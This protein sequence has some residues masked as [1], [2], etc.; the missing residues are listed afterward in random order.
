MFECAKWIWN[1][2]TDTVDQHMEFVDRFDWD[3]GNVSIALS[4][5][6]D[7][8]LWI[9]GVY[10]ASNQYGDMEQYKIYDTIDITS[11]L[12]PGENRLAILVW[13]FGITDSQRYQ[14][15]P[16]GLIY[17][18]HGEN[19]VLAASDEVTLSRQSRA[20]Q[21]GRQKLITRQLGYSFTYDAGAEDNW[22]TEDTEGFTNSQLTDK[23]CTFYPRPNE[24]LTMFPYK[25]A[26]CIH[27]DKEDSHYLLDLG[28]ETVGV[29]RFSLSS[30][31][32]QKIV[33]SYG[34]SLTDGHVRRII[35]A[36]DFSVDYHAREGENDFTHYMLRF[37]GRY[38]EMDGEIPFT[39]HHAGLIPQ[40]FDVTEKPCPYSDPLDREIYKI[41]VNALKLCM[42][43][44]YVDTPWREQC[45]YAYDSRNQMLCGYYAFADGNYAYAR[46]NLLLLAKALRKD[47]L[48][49]IC[50]PCG[51]ELT[52]PSFSMQ[53]IIA[54]KEY[55]EYSG[56]TSLAEE[57]ADVMETLLHT[58]VGRVQDGI[59]Y[60]FADA[61]YWNFFD[62]SPYADGGSIY[63]KSTAHPHL[64]T[65][66]VLILAL[67][68][69]EK[70]CETIGRDNTFAGA[71]D[72]LRKGAYQRFYCREKGLIPV[73]ETEATELENAMAVCAGIVKGEEAKKI[74][75]QITADALIPCSLSLRPFKYDALLM[76]D[77][78]AYRAYILSEIRRDY[79][80]MLEAGSTTVWETILGAVDFDNAGSLCHGWSAVPVYYYA[81]L[82]GSD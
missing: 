45:L 79:G 51:V 66:A 13:H 36:R 3:S 18:V 28:E 24:K 50:A 58:F 4:V 47:G 39:M 22:L 14:N 52:I 70:I 21:S 33:I 54:M 16:A 38:L 62:W 82:L 2:P 59:V 40:S 42:M 30:P 20:Y 35:G 25:K 68:A 41:S 31:T 71:A 55:L 77:K 72:I 81:I 23:E 8:T 56:D 43:E 6:G 48:L 9:N 76:T 44:H 60:T 65:T 10:A 49:P 29:L 57:T 64:L 53:F 67:D 11:L 19:G 37:S 74:C 17:E 78:A 46:S 15:F 5:D 1:G 69:Y 7:Y 61:G 80:K 75:D 63:D 12:K 26:K 73:N 27:S 32:P 34:E